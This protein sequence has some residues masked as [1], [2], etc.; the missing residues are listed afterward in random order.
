MDDTTDTT[1]GRRE[2]LGAAAVAGAAGVGA[3]AG[4][5]AVVGDSPAFVAATIAN[6]TNTLAPAALVTFAITVLG[7]LGSR[8]AY[9]SGL[10]ATALVLAGVAGVAAAAARR[11]D[12][13]MTAPFAVGSGV[14]LVAGFL[15]GSAASAVG[16]AV[17][18]ALVS[19][20]ASVGVGGKPGATPDAARRA[21][22]AGVAAVALG[23]L[24]VAG[25]SRLAGGRTGT[26]E[27]AEPVPEAAAE[28]LATAR[29]RSLDVEGLEPLVSDSFYTVDISNVDPS[30]DPEEWSV[31][32]HGAVE[33]ET[34]FDVSDVEALEG[35]RRFVS[36]RCVGEG[37]NGKKLDTALWTGVP[38]QSL[39]ADAN[40]EGEYV[41]LRAADGFYE[42]F[43]MD[44]LEEG[45]LATR[46][47]GRPLPRAHG[48]PA[49]ALIPGHWGEINVKWLT[50]IEVLDEPATGYWEER[51]WHGTGPVNT[52]A[53]LWATNR[54]DDG[55]VEVAGPAY[56][57]TRG[58]SRVEVS[59]D[60]GETWT[61]ATLSDPLPG[62]DVW[63]QWVHRYDPPAGSHEVVVRA[64]EADG[65]VQPQEE[66][67]AYPNGPSGWVSRTV[68]P[69]A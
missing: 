6:A 36:L 54:L 20:V 23:A 22:L 63:R 2:R 29:E 5:Y 32:V 58:V 42:E 33:S 37:L 64:I 17:G 48:A 46:M 68:D 41:M 57:G 10:A 47:N 59:I 12:R 11:V 35:E 31:R 50:E 8:L 66:A 24:G 45:F 34:T 67:E 52:V 19:T 60:G 61:D 44:A 1:A 62:E 40:P 56:A 15:A 25:Q 53:K 18:A 69:G 13:P 51:G 14:V 65:T 26:D 38:I 28:M 43:P 16:A 49:R 21:T 3:V 30:P 9:L 7:D 4:S 39:I 27:A 55:R